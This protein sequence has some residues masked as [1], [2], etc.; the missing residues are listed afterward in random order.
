MDSA[1]TKRLYFQPRLHSMESGDVR[2]Y[3]S[4]YLPQVSVSFF[5]SYK[6]LHP[7]LAVFSLGKTKT[8]KEVFGRAN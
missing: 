7:C 3:L 4:R 5:D 1:V 2:C 6:L 8:E